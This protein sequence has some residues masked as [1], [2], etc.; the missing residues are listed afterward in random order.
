MPRWLLLL[1]TGTVASTVINFLHSG[2]EEKASAEKAAKQKALED[3][4]E[5]AKEQEA[6][7]AAEAA[8]AAQQAGAGSA[9]GR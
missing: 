9:G 4:P 5:W 7:A 1:I 6:Q 8:A 3:T 2:E